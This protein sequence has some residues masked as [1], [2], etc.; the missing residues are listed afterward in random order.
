MGRGRPRENTQNQLED[1][2][3]IGTETSSRAE[4]LKIIRKTTNKLVLLQTPKGVI[5][6]S[7]VESGDKGKTK[8]REQWPELNTQHRSGGGEQGYTSSTNGTVEITKRKSA[9]QAEHIYEW[10]KKAMGKS[11]C[12]K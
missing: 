5:S 1:E 2:I 12:I 3:K 6:T 10:T 4:P 11:L 8:C 9:G 7:E